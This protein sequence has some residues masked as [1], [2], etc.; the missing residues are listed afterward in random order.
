VPA[1][2]T[3]HVTLTIPAGTPLRGTL[4]V[5]GVG[6]GGPATGDVAQS[7]ASAAGDDR[8]SVAQ[9]VAELND[10]PLN[11]DIVVTFRPETGEGTPPPAIEAVGGTDWFVTGSL[12][13]PTSSLRLSA[14]PRTISY[15]GGTTLF[16]TIELVAGDTVVNIYATPKGSTARKL[17]ATVPAEAYGQTATFEYRVPK[18]KSTTRFTAVWGGD[19]ANLGSTGSVVVTVRPRVTR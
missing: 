2:Q 3:A 15:G 13:L 8:Q 9:L 19:A 4:E 16:G 14:S 17:V 5:F 6:G 10:L 7:R 1:L 11:S 18:M 12:Q